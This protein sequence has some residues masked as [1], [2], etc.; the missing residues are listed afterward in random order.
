MNSSVLIVGDSGF[1]AQVIS[2]VRGHTALTLSTAEF[3]AAAELIQTEPPD[4]VILQGS[5]AEAWSLCRLLKQQR[6]L[7]S[8]Y[9]LL[10]DDRIWPT[11]SDEAA[12][13]QHYVGLTITALE[14]GAD[15]YVWLTLSALEVQM[16]AF[17]DHQRRLFQAQLRSGLRRV[18]SYRELS[19]ANDLLSA[20]ALSDPLTQLS[21]RRAFDWELPRQVA[22]AHQQDEALSLLMIDI[23]HFKS[24]N[25]TYGHLVGDQVLQLVAERL[26][27]NMRFYEMPFRYGGEEFVVILNGADAA[28]ALKIGE[29]ICRL[30]AEEPFVVND[31][32]ALSITVSVGMAWLAADDNERGVSLLDRADQNLLKAKASGRNQVVS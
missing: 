11:D 24:I 4:L 6:R 2:Q 23:D 20:I 1:P 5:R 29:R 31:S 32:L 9:C 21:N 28:A 18:Q 15:A 8:L 19:R 22:A 13:L 10:V 26:S 14:A 3:E 7:S 12:L 17:V 25:D 16:S 30:I 27:Q